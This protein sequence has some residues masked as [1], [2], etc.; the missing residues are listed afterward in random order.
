M[1]KIEDPNNLILDIKNFL[2]LRQHQYLPK[3]E[4]ETTRFIDLIEIVLTMFPAADLPPLEVFLPGLYIRQLEI[5]AGTLGTSKIHRTKHPFI[6]QSG[7]ISVWTLRSGCQRFR[8]PHSG[9]TVPGTRRVLYAHEDT[10]WTTIHPTDLKDPD[11][12]EQLLIEPHYNQFL[13]CLSGSSQE[14]R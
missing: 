4:E 13:P 3:D 6:V 7:D 1:I 2:T 10:V 14:Q 9:I 5:P 8:G 12:I 11:E